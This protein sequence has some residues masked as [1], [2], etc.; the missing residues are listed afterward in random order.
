MTAELHKIIVRAALKLLAEKSD[1]EIEKM[2][3]FPVARKLIDWCVANPRW[4]D[5]EMT[6]LL[7]AVLEMSKQNTEM[8]KNL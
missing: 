8:L 5:P 6:S 2:I 7:N 3:G 4:E 1:Q